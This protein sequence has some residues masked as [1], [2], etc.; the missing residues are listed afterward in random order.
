[1]TSTKVRALR[2]GIFIDGSNLLWA[3]KDIDSKTGK[4]KNYNICF[5]KLKSYLKSKYSP[6]FYNYYVCVDT[7]PLK[8]PYITRAGKA[9]KFHDFLEGQGY[10][11]KKKDLKILKCGDTKC[12]TDIEV[13]MD[14]HKYVNDIDNIILFTGDSDFKT[15]VEGFHAQ[16]KHIRIYSFKS[17]LSWELKEFAIKNPRCNYILLDD[18]KD[19]LERVI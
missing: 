15:A 9:K 2:T 18:L 10:N 19:K 13:V 5:T 14:L 17:N 3:V 4:K 12:D 1:M 6:V 8:E 7:K 11:V 16:G